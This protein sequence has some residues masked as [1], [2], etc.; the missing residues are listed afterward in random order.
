VDLHHLLL[1]GHGA[2]RARGIRH[3]CDVIGCG[4]V[5]DLLLQPQWLLA[6]M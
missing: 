4:H 2:R 6:M 1:A 5:F 3:V